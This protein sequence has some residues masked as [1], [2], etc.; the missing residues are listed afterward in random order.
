MFV[1]VCV[2]V[3]VYRSIYRSINNDNTLYI[4]L[5]VANFHGRFA[6]IR[7]PILA[8]ATLP[9]IPTWPG[10]RGFKTSSSCRDGG[11]WSWGES[12]ACSSTLPSQE[13]R[14]HPT[15]LVSAML[16]RCLLLRLGQRCSRHL[17]PSS[18]R[19]ARVTGRDGCK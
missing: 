4:D 15:R 6:F 12:Q 8:I 10:R 3:C 9:G 5:L 2:C 17:A 14:I 19:K 1:C 18:L 13:S 16:S 11:S 7:W